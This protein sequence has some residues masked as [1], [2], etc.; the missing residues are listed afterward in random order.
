MKYILQIL[1]L[2]CGSAFAL[3]IALIFDLFGYEDIIL[4]LIFATLGTILL[5]INAYLLW[6]TREKNKQNI[7]K[8]VILWT[9]HNLKFLFIPGYHLEDLENRRSQHELLNHKTRRLFRYKSK[10]FIIGICTIAILCTVAV[11]Q[12]W[13]SPYTYEE[14]TY[15]SG[16]YLKWFAPPSPEHPLG[17]TFYGF[18]ILARLI[19][20]TRPVLVFT[21]SATLIASLLG[22]F[23]GAIS[24]YYGG[25]LDAIVMRIMDILLSFP[26]IIF[27]I[28][29][30]TI[31]GRDY[32]TLI[33]IYSIIGIP[34]F[35][36]IIRTNVL[37]EKEL[38]YIP[39]AKASGSGNRRILFRHILPNCMQSFIPAASYN[40]SR[41]I[42]SLTILG[43][44]RLGGIYWI[45]WGF[46]ITTVVLFQRN[47]PNAPWALFYPCLMILITVLGFLLLG[48]SLS[49]KNLLKQEKL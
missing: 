2:L 11:L 34:Y 48:D 37:K 35:A 14:V 30:I 45:E 7:T 4:G 22:I 32:I 25:W 39:A 26:G 1:G 47:L 12:D 18:D 3:S 10:L 23:I 6:K 27:A 46:D 42:I 40:I 15:Y 19:F 44:L 38:P 5:F 16:L 49:D 31:W 21:L 17:T 41:N 29:F 36:R 24:G 20:G 9:I 28:I 8:K 43:F 33:M 13:I